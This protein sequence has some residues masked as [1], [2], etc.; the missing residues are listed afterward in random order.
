MCAELVLDTAEGGVFPQ[1]GC[2]LSAVFD[3]KQTE[4]AV[5]LLEHEVIGLPY[6]LGGGPERG[7][8]V[9]KDRFDEGSI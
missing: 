8:G 6:L 3:C 9:G 7:P 1:A 4:V 2:D 5:S